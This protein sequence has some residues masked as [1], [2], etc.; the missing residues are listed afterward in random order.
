MNALPGSVRAP[1]I[2]VH[3]V[4]QGKTA[5]RENNFRVGVGKKIL[6]AK[7]INSQGSPV[8]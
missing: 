6:K 8:A 2:M 4:E 5:V 1:P 7:A 3:P